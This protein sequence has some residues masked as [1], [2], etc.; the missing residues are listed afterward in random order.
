MYVPSFLLPSADICQ[1][2]SSF[3][4]MWYKA[5]RL[6]FTC[7]YTYVRTKLTILKQ[8]NSLDRPILLNIYQIVLFAYGPGE[9]GPISGRVIPKTL[10]M[11]PDTSSL[12]TRQY[13]ARIRVKWSNP[14]KSVVSSP[15]PWCGRYWKGAFGSP[16]T[17]ATNFTYFNLYIYIYIYIYIYTRNIR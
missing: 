12:N 1:F 4:W 10:K 13:K 11:V 9:L 7:V 5:M 3:V 6:E 2:T 17:T 16:T 15:T 8:Y 14:G